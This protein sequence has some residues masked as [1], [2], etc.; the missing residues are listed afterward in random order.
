LKDLRIGIIGNPDRN[1]ITDAL[2]MLLNSL[3]EF[4]PKQCLLAD[5]VRSI[6]DDASCQFEED[7]YKIAKCSD[8]IFALGGDGTMLGASRAIMRANPECKLL[9]INLGKLGFIAENHPDVIPRLVSSLNDGSLKTERRLIVTASITSVD[10]P[11][12]VIVKHDDLSPER[13]GKNASSAEMLA[14][15]EIVIDNFGSTRMLTFEV[16]VNGALLGIMRADGLIVASPTGSTGYAVSAGGPIIEPTSPVMLITPIAPHSLSVR[17]I[18]V[19]D[20]SEILIRAR[21]NETRQALV[22]ADGQEEVIA[23]TTAEV[24]IKACEQKLNLLRLPDNSY[25]DLL[26]EKMFWSVDPVEGTKGRR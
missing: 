26:R 24:R 25:F 1:G 7:H 4:K 20:G 23:T 12:G 21:S 8:V 15:N 9:G 6:V 17:P 16:L 19:D 3:K 2:G 13:E 11:N 5:D 10:D 18:I 14:L 22:V